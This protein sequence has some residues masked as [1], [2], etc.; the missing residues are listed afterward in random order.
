MGNLPKYLTIVPFVQEWI[1]YKGEVYF[2]SLNIE[3]S[4]KSK[5][6]MY[7]LHYCITKM[8]NNVVIKTVAYHKDKMF[9]TDKAN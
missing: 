5:R 6:L 9:V 1:E 4:V 3:Q 8:L 7:D 2:A